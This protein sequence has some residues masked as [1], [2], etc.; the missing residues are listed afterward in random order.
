[1]H[2]HKDTTHQPAHIQLWPKS[3][4]LCAVPVIP[5]A[6]SVM[7]LLTQTVKLATMRF[8]HLLAAPL[9]LNAS[10]LALV[11]VTNAQCVT[12]NAMAVVEPPTETVYLAVNLT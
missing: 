5:T 7:D 4:P 6:L 9:S 3:L 1:M 11:Q 12:S 8:R 2:A 10:A